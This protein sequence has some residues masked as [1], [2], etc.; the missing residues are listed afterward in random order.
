[1]RFCMAYHGYHKLSYIYV[2]SNV[3][4]PKLAGILIKSK[5]RRTQSEGITF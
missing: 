4:N 3:E 5:L 2:K 1:M